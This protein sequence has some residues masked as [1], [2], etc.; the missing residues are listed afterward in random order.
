MTESDVYIQTDLPLDALAA[1]VRERTGLALQY[2]EFDRGEPGF[3]CLDGT[4]RIALSTNAFRLAEDAPLDAFDYEL[5]VDGYEDAPRLQY[6]RRLF[7][8]LAAVGTM[9][10]LL[11]D[12]LEVIDRFDPPHRAK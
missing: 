8:Q 5:D 7:E 10:L 11:V 4:R 9:P 6:A 3:V 2:R 12:D 1:L